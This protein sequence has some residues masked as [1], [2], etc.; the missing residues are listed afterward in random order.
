M[1]H[2]AKW[3][4]ISSIVSS[5]L[6]G[7]PICK[8]H[9][10]LSKLAF[11]TPQSDLTRQAQDLAILSGIRTGPG[12]IAPSTLLRTAGSGYDQEPIVRRAAGWSDASSKRHVCTPPEHA[13]PADAC[14]FNCLALQGAPA[15]RYCP[16]HIWQIFFGP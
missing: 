11:H 15:L 7:S 2:S 13:P 8:G 16:G 5:S 3:D 10:M 9:A 6:K 14:C 12:S 4:L 1:A